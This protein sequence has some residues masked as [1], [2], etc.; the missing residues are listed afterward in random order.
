MNKR[1][2][3]FADALVR[4]GDVRE[5]R[6][7]AGYSESGYHRLLHD[8]KFRGEL[9]ARGIDIRDGCVIFSGDRRRV[10]EDELLGEISALRASV[11]RDASLKLSDRLSAAQAIE[12]SI[13][14]SR[15]AA[16]AAAVGG[17]GECF[18]LPAE[19]IGRAFVDINREIRPNVS[20]IFTGGRGSGK[21]S[22]IALKV[23]ELLLRNPQLHACVVRKLATTLRDSV[24][25]QLVWA[26]G[27]LG[28]TEYF[29][30][31]TSPLEIVYSPTGQ[32]IFFRGVDDAAKLKSTKAPFGYIG[33]LWKEEADQL[34]G[35]AEARGI[36]QSVLRGGSVSYDFSSYNP[37]RSRKHWINLMMRGGYVCHH[38][39]Y[40]DMPS[41]WLG[42]KFISDAEH[43]RDV[44]Y[45]S[46]EHEYLGVANGVGG[47]VFEHL[48]VR[49]ISDAEISGFDR[50]YQG[51]DFGWYPDPFAFIRLHYDSARGV[52][53]ILDELYAVK[54]PNADAADWLIAR[55][56]VD[57]PIICD[58]AEPKSV[59]ELRR[60]GVPALCAAKGAGSVAFG[61][62]WLASRVIVVD[63]A[64]TPNAYR[65]LTCYEFSPGGGFPD[66]DDHALSAIR[67]ALERAARGV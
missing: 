26:I 54:L 18:R 36:A 62:K 63:P 14:E 13:A 50:I 43:L 6:A 29:L 19:V 35:E 53:Y 56:Y 57:E 42:V 16:G 31:H 20:Y 15:A 8:E 67:Y 48:E 9:C 27:V 51:I 61:F 24:Y 17:V 3:L 4:T 64:R 28:L 1:Q 39:T 11:M 12:R 32:V 40:L 60:C 10:G 37:P 49:A 7:A 45:A 5:A 30:F 21:S 33:I 65:E 2:A 25:A 47:A 34:S 44:D 38:S 55:G 22:F 23:I 41:E 46:Y 59:D 58:S 52:I 66:R